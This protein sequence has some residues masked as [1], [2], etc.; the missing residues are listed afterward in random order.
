MGSRVHELSSCGISPWNL[1]GPGIEPVSSALVAK[2]LAT[3]P[4]GKSDGFNLKSPAALHPNK[5]QFCPL[6]L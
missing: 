3:G 6:K 4:A 5:S 2:F 1:P